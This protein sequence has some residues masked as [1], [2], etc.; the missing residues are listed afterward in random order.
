MTDWRSKRGA[1]VTFQITRKGSCVSI[2]DRQVWMCEGRLFH[3]FHVN[4]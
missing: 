3:K 1:L 2:F 4:F